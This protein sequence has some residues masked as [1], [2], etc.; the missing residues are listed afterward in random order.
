[1]LLLGACVASRALAGEATQDVLEHHGDPTRSGHYVVPGLTWEA[2][3]HLHLAPDFRADVAGPVYA[4]PLFWR[5]PGSDRALLLVATEQNAVYALDSQSGSVVWRTVVGPPAP[6]SSLPCGNIDPLGITGTPVI[7][8]ASQ[9]LYLAAMLRDKAS[10]EPRHFIFGL[11]LKDG[12]VLPGWPVDVEAALKASGKTFHS[13]VQGQRGALIVVGDTLY[14]PY[15]GHFG[16]CGDY[17]GWVV[18]VSLR[19]PQ[20]VRSWSTRARGGGLWAAGGISSDGS[21]LYVAT[22]NTIGAR[23]WGDGEAV[24]HLGTDLRFSDRAE[25][26]FAPTNWAR[27]DGADDDL[28]G[29]NVVLL[30]LQGGAGPEFVLA[31]G[32]DG[33]AYLMDRRRLGGIG[34]SLLVKRV[35]SDAIRAAPAYLSTDS[36]AL[37][38]SQGRGVDC[39]AG[40]SGDLTVLRIAPGPPP[41]LGVAWCAVENGRGAP[42][43][44][45]TDGRADPI[46]WVVGAEGHN[47][48]RGFR[49]DTGAVLYDGGSA[50]EAMSEVRR[51]QTLIAVDRHLYVAADQRVYA[52]AF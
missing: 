5:V 14:V 11:S 36:G 42:I 33:N 31:L 17:R 26:F 3:R 35:S 48:L 9:A 27:L 12:S 24:I 38:A 34:G 41:T 29:T 8:R 10:G 13:A 39:P 51:F 4:Q 28:G 43:I 22:G 16:D 47:R 46:V 25:D 32:K 6:H 2:A 37:V 49:A 21:G 52:F 20:S 40:Q 1:M 18:G 15:G 50:A 23:Q 30:G 44:T 19:K 45:T 7:D